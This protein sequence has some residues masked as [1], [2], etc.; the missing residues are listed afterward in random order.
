MQSFRVF[1]INQI[2]PRAPCK[3]LAKMLRLEQASRMLCS[4]KALPNRS[5]FDLIRM[6][7][8]I[9]GKALDRL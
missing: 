1:N 7:Q 9:S 8:K 3:M 4:S 5:A 6:A 2:H